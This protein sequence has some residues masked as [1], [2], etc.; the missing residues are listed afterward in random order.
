MELV[1]F[2]RARLDEDEAIARV[3]LD[4]KRPGRAERWEFCDDAAIRDTGR[5]R[6]LRVKF[7][8]APEAEHIV[9]HD[10]ARALA[11]VEAGRQAITV[12]EAARRNA[13]LP[14]PE[15]VEGVYVP[16]VFVKGYAAAMEYNLRLRA[17]SFRD[18]PDFDPAWLED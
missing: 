18:H 3:L 5:S 2:L 15:H 1:D 6:S 14:H 11:E 17:R 4:D 12:Y 8:W 10:P 9:R 16:D 13:S 7:T